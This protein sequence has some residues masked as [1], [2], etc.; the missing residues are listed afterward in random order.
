MVELAIEIVLSLKD[1]NSFIVRSE[2]RRHSDPP[3]CKLRWN[4]ALTNPLYNSFCLGRER[5]SEDCSARCAII[6]L[7]VPIYADVVALFS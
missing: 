6:D 5:G 7:L 1:A 2:L 4:L 3:R